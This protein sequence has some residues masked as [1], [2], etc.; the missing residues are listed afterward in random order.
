M[1]ICLCTTTGKSARHT[2]HCI[3]VLLVRT[4][5]NAEHLGREDRT[6]NTARVV[7]SP[8]KPTQTVLLI[9]TDQ[10]AE[11]LGREDKQGTQRE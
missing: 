4:D 5:Q 9:H 11:H 2:G 3:T 1:G 10:H 8:A 6:R 7:S